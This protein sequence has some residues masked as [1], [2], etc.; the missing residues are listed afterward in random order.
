MGKTNKTPTF[1]AK[2]PH[3]KVPAFEGEDG[4]TI[5]DSDA[6]ARY[7]AESGPLAAQLVGETPQ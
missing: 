3:G 1:L 6:I 5:F 4:T 2:F 7:V